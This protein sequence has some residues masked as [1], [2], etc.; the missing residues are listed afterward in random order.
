MFRRLGT[1]VSVCAA[2]LLSTTHARSMQAP[3]TYDAVTDR[4][5]RAKPPLIDLGPAGFSFNDPVF[6]SR[7]WRVTDRLTVNLGLRWELLSPF[8]DEHGIQANFDPKTNA[9]I[10]NDV[11]Y[12]TLGGP[13]PAFLQSFNA[14][15]AAPPGFSAPADAGYVP[16]AS[17]P[18]TA[19]VSNSH[20][21]LATG[22]RQTYF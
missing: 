21:G 9:V 10:V 16:S 20:E 8:V 19:V 22:L 17:L 18:C 6:G 15:N 11:L 12:R 4:G 14:C 13:V 1:A 7:I 5:A 3:L 2:L